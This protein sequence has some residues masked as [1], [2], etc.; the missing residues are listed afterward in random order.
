MKH[1]PYK[2]KHELV[3]RHILAQATYDGTSDRIT[4]K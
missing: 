4:V 3:T 1:R 2:D